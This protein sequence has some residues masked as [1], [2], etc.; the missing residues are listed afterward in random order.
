MQPWRW[1]RKVWN[2]PLAPRRFQPEVEQ[3]ETRPLFA[4]GLEAAVLIDPDGSLTA[5]I[6][7]SPARRTLSDH[8]R[9]FRPP[10][11]PRSRGRTRHAVEP[12]RSRRPGVGPERGGVDQEP[13]RPHH[14]APLGREL[15]SP[16]RGTR[17]QH[18]R[19]HADNRILP[20]SPPGQPIPTA[21]NSSGMVMGITTATAPSTCW[22][23]IM[24]PLRLGAP[25]PGTALF[26]RTGRSRWL[27]QQHAA[28]GDF[29]ADGRLDPVLVNPYANWVVVLLARRRHVSGPVQ[30]RRLRASGEKYE[31]GAPGMSRWMTE[32]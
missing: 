8:R 4:G 2:R 25:R 16:R 28:Q 1:I 20:A 22:A 11:R 14:A 18:G 6:R 19:L 10:Y 26:S 12:A 29:N 3:L 7:N 24:T 17:G 32:R 23:S 30:V 27:R 15:L 13:R 31:V 5:D 21:S 9:G